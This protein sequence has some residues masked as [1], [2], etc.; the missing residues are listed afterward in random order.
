V[1]EVATLLLKHGMDGA[2]ATNTTISREGVED[3]P[4]GM[5]TG[6]LSGSPLR[7]KSTAVLRRLCS[8]LNGK[9]PVIGVGGILSARDALEKLDAGACLVQIYTGLIYRG[10]GLIREV[11]E[12]VIQRERRAPPAF[13]SIT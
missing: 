8:A 3:S 9:L 10:P 6:G 5:E 13:S 1:D 11:V 4:V 2:I 7:E 12:A